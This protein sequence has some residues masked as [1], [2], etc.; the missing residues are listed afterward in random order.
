MEINSNAIMFGTDLPST[1]AKRPFEKSDI[2]LIEKNFSKEEQK[3]LLQKC[4][5][6]L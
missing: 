4:D 3:D 5:A 2:E 1:R 6:F